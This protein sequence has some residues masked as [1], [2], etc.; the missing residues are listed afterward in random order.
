MSK[1]NEEVKSSVNKNKNG[2][3]IC[4]KCGEKIKFNTKK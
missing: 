1:A 2:E 4:P 3:I